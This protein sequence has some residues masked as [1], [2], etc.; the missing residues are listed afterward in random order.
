MH[1]HVHNELAGMDEPITKQ[2]IQTAG[3]GGHQITFG[4][5]IEEFLAQAQT[6]DALVAPPWEILRFDLFKAPHLKLLQ[7]TSAGVDRLAPFQCIP[8]GVILMNNR[9]TH[10]AKAGEYALM[11][12]LMLVNQMPRFATQQ[13]AELWSRQTCTLARKYRITIMGLGSL[14]GAAACHAKY[15]G[16]NVTGISR[17]GAAHPHCDQVMTDVAMVEILPNTDI[18]LLA[19]PL[20]TETRNIISAER[21]ALL[22]QD[23]GVINIGRGPLLDQD[24]LFTA[25]NAGKLGAAVLDVCNP[26]PLPP[27][28][29]AWTT[30]NLIITPHMSSDDPGT[31]N[32][33]TLA[34]FTRNITAF[35]AG[36]TP[37]TAVDFAKGY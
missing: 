11:A 15:L 32:A 9:G 33:D 28:H 18:L 4:T 14:G 5:S 22:P 26:E 36:Q 37:P 21:I 30:K 13:R 17:S 19:C 31:Y 7:S 34:I 6:M 29:P 23:A 20:T 3:L 1:I 25:L 12:I 16:M 8:P 2:D 10:A 27:G 24:A 35:A